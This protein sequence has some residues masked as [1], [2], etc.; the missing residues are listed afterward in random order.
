VNLFLLQVLLLQLYCSFITALW[1][2]FSF[3]IFKYKV[4][5]CD[6]IATILQLC[7]SFI[8]AS[9]LYDFP[10]QSVFIT[11]LLQLYRGFVAACPYLASTNTLYLCLILSQ[12]CCGLYCGFIAAA[13]T[14]HICLGL[15]YR[16]CDFFTALL[17]TLPRP[18]RICLKPFQ[19]EWGAL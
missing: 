13:S 1:R 4:C 10:A 5:Y 11:T 14:I 19:L 18:R 17:R 2:L 9:L 12:L 3:T 6:F 16:Y 8:E 7:C 15:T